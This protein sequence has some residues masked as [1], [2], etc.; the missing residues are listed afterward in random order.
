MCFR[1]GGPRRKKPG[2]EERE[3]GILEE[4][5]KRGHL[6]FFFFHVQRECDQSPSRG[7]FRIVTWNNVMFWPFSD[8]RICETMLGSTLAGF[9][10]LLVL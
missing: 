10:P 8:L 2:T 7:H 1:E 6:L 3:G 5:L 4:Y 9:H